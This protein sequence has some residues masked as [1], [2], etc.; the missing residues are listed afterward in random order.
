MYFILQIGIISETFL[1]MEIERNALMA[2]PTEIKTKIIHFLGTDKLLALSGTCMEMNEL[3]TN[4]DLWAQRNCGSSYA[5]GLDSS[6]ML[7]MLDLERF[8]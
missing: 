6:K 7:K 2:L 1:D 3:C 4:P 8:I 5:W